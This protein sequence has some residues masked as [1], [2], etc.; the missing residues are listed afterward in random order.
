M[1]VW[2]LFQRVGGDTDSH[3]LVTRMCGQSGFV[4]TR[5][6]RARHQQT[7]RVCDVALCP[8]E[9]TPPELHIP[10]ILLPND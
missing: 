4:N 8:V 2:Q 6:E 5:I 7:E 9:V 10:N 1:V 3:T